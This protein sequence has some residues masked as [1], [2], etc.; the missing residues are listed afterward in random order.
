M[1]SENSPKKVLREFLSRQLNHKAVIYHLPEEQRYEVAVYLWEQKDVA[2]EPVW[3]RV[4]GPFLIEDYAAA[5]KL[6]QETL[7]LMSGELRDQSVA[8]EKEEWLRN[9]SHDASAVFLAPK[10]FRARFLEE[11]GAYKK[12][13]PVKIALVHEIYIVEAAGKWFLGVLEEDDCIDCWAAF[14]SFAEISGG[15]SM[16]MS[17]GGE[18]MVLKVRNTR[19]VVASFSEPFWIKGGMSKRDEMITAAVKRCLDLKA[20]GVLKFGGVVDQA[21]SD[22]TNAFD[23]AVTPPP[24]LPCN[25]KRKS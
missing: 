13:D 4:S 8:S 18:P 23:A 3:K 15:G 7:E 24:K 5:E 6:A 1:V 11:T 21:R 9:Y 16:E 12:I 22:L 14:D 2:A 19:Q 25:N 10:N 17:L 20:K